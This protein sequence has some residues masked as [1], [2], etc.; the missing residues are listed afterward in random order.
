MEFVFIRVRDAAEST[1]NLEQIEV[2][3]EAL[4][5]AVYFLPFVAVKKYIERGEAELL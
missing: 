5:G 2:K 3:M 4:P 1:W